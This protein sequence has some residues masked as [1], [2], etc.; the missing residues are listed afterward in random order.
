MMPGFGPEGGPMMPPGPPPGGNFFDNF[1]N[2]QQDMNMDGVVEEGEL[3]SYCIMNEAYNHCSHQRLMLAPPISFQIE[4]KPVLL[5]VS[6]SVVYCSCQPSSY[7]FQVITS[8][9]L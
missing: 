2:Q 1:F 9:A 4:S 7:T 6:E 3:I 8:R 5:C